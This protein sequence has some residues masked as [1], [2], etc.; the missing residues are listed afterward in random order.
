MFQIELAPPN[1]NIF[2]VFLAIHTDS[3]SLDTIYKSTELSVTRP[4]D[5]FFFPPR[6]EGKK[7]LTTLIISLKL[8]HSVDQNGGFFHSHFAVHPNNNA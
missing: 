8:R 3:S 6:T 4:L 1:R 7:K 5:F 2:H